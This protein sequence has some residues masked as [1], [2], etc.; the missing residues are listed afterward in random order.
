MTSN[1]IRLQIPA[2]AEYIH[3]V[4]LCLYGIASDMG[5]SFEDIDDMKV[6]VAEA[7]NNSVLH[8]YST[9]NPGVIEIDFI[10]QDA[11]LSIKVKDHGTSFNN[12]DVSVK[13]SPLQDVEVG[14]LPVGGLGIY[15][16]QAL[17]DEVIISSEHGTEVIMTKYLTAKNPLDGG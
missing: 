8:G 6:A 4:R 7:C 9:N 12:P 3:I 5:F 1:P 15:L 10:V 14:E 16:M 2:D 17:M 13:P 11:A